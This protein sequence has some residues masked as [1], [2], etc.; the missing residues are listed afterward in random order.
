LKH[1]LEAIVS[2]PFEVSKTRKDLETNKTGEIRVDASQNQR[3]AN[4]KGNDRN[5]KV[6]LAVRTNSPQKP[7]SPSHVAPKLPPD[8][9][10][11]V[12]VR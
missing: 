9:L 8:I 5:G 3:P 7:S 4:H 10:K 1:G 2:T 11:N 6:G 12:Q